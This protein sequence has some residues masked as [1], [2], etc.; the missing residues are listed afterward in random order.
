ML[1]IKNIKIEAKF[2]VIFAL[3]V[4][5]GVLTTYGLLRLS[6]LSK[7][8][9]QILSDVEYV[10]YY[11]KKKPASLKTFGTIRKGDGVS[12]SAWENFSSTFDTEIKN[13]SKIIELNESKIKEFSEFKEMKIF[14]NL[15]IALDKLLLFRDESQKRIEGVSSFSESK[16][17]SL[18][19]DIQN[20]LGKIREEAKNYSLD[21]R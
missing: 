13:I 17:S 2:I 11:I 3:I 15:K 9:K 20:I 18:E 21:L 5:I 10:Y 14:S 19:A 4:L 12:R 6:S 16:L 8:K 1:R 7:E